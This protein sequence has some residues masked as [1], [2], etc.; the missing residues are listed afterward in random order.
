MSYKLTVKSKAKRVKLLIM[1]VDGV[2]T[3]GR[4]ILDDRGRELK[5]FDV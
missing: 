1:D 3:D 5:F 2:L 4:S